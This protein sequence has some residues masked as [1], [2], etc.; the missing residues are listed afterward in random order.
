MY[1]ISLVAAF[2]AGMVALFAPCCVSYLFPSYLGNIF[3]EKKQILL[4]TL[5]YSLGIFAVMMPIVLGA[6][7]LQSLFFKLHDTTYLIG[8]IFML[9]VSVISLLGIKLP[10]P[11]L[12]YKTKGQKSDILSNFML[13][14][15]SGIT[16][17]CCAP[18][19]I[20]VITLSALNPTTWQALG[21]GASYVAG[22]VTPL[23][24][25]SLLIDRKNILE[26]PVLK[27]VLT[28][29]KLGKRI[30]PIFVSN[31]IAFLIF[32][33]TGVIML[34]LTSLGKLGMSSA[35]GTITKSINDVAI[36]I[37]SITSSVPGLDI[38]F[39]I[40]G[41]GLMYK[42]IKSAFSPKKNKTLA[43]GK[44]YCPM[45]PDVVSDKPG[46][47]PKCGTMELVKMTSEE[48]MKN[49]KMDHTQHDHSSMM[50]SPEAAKDFLRRFLIVTALLAPLL[51]FKTPLVR[52]GIAT[53][54]FYFGLVF[55]KHAK[56]EIAMRKY[57]MMTL[58]S[59]G[60][61]SGYLFSVA[62]TFIPAL[63]AEFYLEISTLIWVL[64]FGHFL[65]AKSSSAAGDA[66]KEVAKLLPK[67]AHL[68]KGKTT[69]DVDVDILK[70]GDIVLVKA[71][72][73]IPADGV[74]IKGGGNFNES[75]ITG[76]S[77][78]VSKTSK[79]QVVA[80]SINIDGSVEVK[81]TR[82]GKSSTI[83]QIK[84]LIASAKKTKPSVQRLADRA[85]AWLTFSALGVSIITLLVWSLVLGQPLVFAITLAIT[86][87][88]IA[89]PHAL[90]LAI[91]TVSTIATKLAV[92]NG[93]FIKDMSKIEVVKN[94]TYVV[95]DKTGTLTEGSFS[96]TS[97]DLSNSLLSIVS[98]IE[99]HSSHVIGMSIVDFAKKKKAKSL[100]VS[101][102]KNIA[103]MG[104]E[105]TVEGK[106]YIVGSYQYMKKV[107]LNANMPEEG[108]TTV[109]LAG[110][111][112]V[113]GSISLSDKLK[114]ESKKTV[115]SLHKLGAKV[116][117]I[118]GDTK[119]V[120]DK[121]ASALGV[122][123]V[124]AEVLPKDKYKYIKKLQDEGNVVVMAGDGVND[125][126]ALTQA[127]VGVAI[128]AGTDVAV[129]A[130]DVVLTQSN[131]QD[132]VRL[133]IL[134]KKVY[135][136]MIENLYWALGYNVLAIPAA[137]GLFIPFGFRLTPS[138]GAL[139]MSLSS[140]IVV[141]NALTLRKIKLEVI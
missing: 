13:G 124:F 137:A 90:G 141:I 86:V 91:P 55:F 10:M 46:K 65:E 115:E 88:V 30:Y 74:I 19:L 67:K 62:S 5:V 18:V 33:V 105:A 45:H 24:L 11:H 34:W 57:G 12:S 84:D 21:V 129:E 3:K 78:P 101:N 139:L 27:K 107:G 63:T 66:L 2:I 32:A 69:K 8:G 58:V 20:G 112:K 125:A 140:V 61:G 122:D 97:S 36:N 135:K 130:G 73:K 60:I 119:S 16:S 118:T 51:I 17:A 110:D 35:E 43:N 26:K 92:K 80:G 127:D 53:V 56:M 22:M 54:I 77:K 79:D 76:E 121:V 39:A 70:S 93:L 85:S 111:K 71:G 48:D 37:S 68:I 41:I 102:V 25:A 94:A 52:F 7:A 1:N 42:F 134:S 123:K 113:L 64:L 120:A 49:Q 83:G 131:P 89:C 14:V 75:H 98:S 81:L 108:L 9:F 40:I 50:A 23:Y 138:I 104:M 59:L 126:P 103:G 87:L 132:L 116:A 109:Y 96:V 117:M 95:F 47:C 114:K 128:G 82:V 136:K 72:E 4:M 44:Y 100:K 28:E 99:K 38:I 15:F 106:K 29:I 133:I 6:K 31:L